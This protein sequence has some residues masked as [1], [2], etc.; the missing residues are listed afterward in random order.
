MNDF[1]NSS[2]IKTVT[3]CGKTLNAKDVAKIVAFSNA[4]SIAWS[5]AETWVSPTR[6]T[7]I[8][9]KFF[10]GKNDEAFEERQKLA[11]ELGAKV[12][13]GYPTYGEGYNEYF[14]EVINDAINWVSYWGG[15]KLYTCLRK[16]EDGS[17]FIDVDKLEALLDFKLGDDVRER[18][19]YVTAK[20]DDDDWVFDSATGR[21]FRDTATVGILCEVQDAVN[22]VD[23]ITQEAIHFVKRGVTTFEEIAN[24]SYAINIDRMT[25]GDIDDVVKAIKESGATP[26]EYTVFFSQDYN[27]AQIIETS[28]LTL[29]LIHI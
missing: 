2:E 18:L 26:E 15:L 13:T 23:S 9:A 22:L 19:T 3:I 14:A 4:G 5:G 8:L 17:R 25:Q 1:F 20:K 10:L 16:N 24:E 6:V 29:S 11:N 28:R 27:D 12:A 21:A 7:T